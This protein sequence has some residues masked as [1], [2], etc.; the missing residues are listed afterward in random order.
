MILSNL[1]L[2]IEHLLPKETVNETIDK[3]IHEV[4]DIFYQPDIGLILENVEMDGT[5]S[6]TIDGRLI[7]PGHGLEA[8]WFMMDL[9][10]H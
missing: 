2:E 1:V 4:M 5:P 10:V 3:A 7:N 9:A 6:D 8:L